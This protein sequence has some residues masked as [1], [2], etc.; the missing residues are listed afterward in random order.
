LKTKYKFVGLSI[1][2]NFEVLD[3]WCTNR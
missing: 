2:K 3:Q 1:N